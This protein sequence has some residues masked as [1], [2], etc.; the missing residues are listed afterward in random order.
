M[1]V[2]RYPFTVRPW[3]GAAI[4]ALAC[5]MQLAACG[6]SDDDSP[7]ASESPQ[8][9][10]VQGPTLK[11]SLS[12]IQLTTALKNGGANGRGL[13]A[14]ASGDAS[15]NATLACGV[16]THYYQYSTVDARGAP[17]TASGAIMLPD[18]PTGQCGGA[19]PMV[20]WAHGTNFYRQYNLA[21][22]LNASNPAASEGLVAASIYAS[23]GFIVVAPN[24]VG[25]DV[26]AASAHPYLNRIQQGQ[27]MVHAV[28]AA[29]LA[30]KAPPTPLVVSDSGKLFVSGYSQ[31]G[32]VAIAAQEAMERAGIKVTATAAGSAPYAI[33]TQV[34]YVYMGQPGYYGAMT[35]EL[36]FQGY[37]AA[38]GNIYSTPAEMLT[39]G[40]LVP[41]P[42]A[43]N[44]EG[45]Q[46]IVQPTTPMFSAAAPS[47]ADI[48]GAISVTVPNDRLSALLATTVPTGYVSNSPFAQAVSQVAWSQVFDP[49][50]NL[51]S[52][53]AAVSATSFGV[54]GAH[55]VR[56]SYRAAYLA[57]AYSNPDGFFLTG[58]AGLP[59]GTARNGLRIALARND[60]RGYVPTAPTLLC[61]TS[62]DAVVYFPLNT[63]AMQASW[64]AP[65]ATR[66]TFD[67]ASAPVPSGD[68]SH[69]FNALRSA[70][71]ASQGA[72]A[73][74]AGGGT[75]GAVA[76]RAQSH[77]TGS[78]FCNVAARA[79]FAN[80]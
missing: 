2:A 60:L 22:F 35:G 32:Y 43:S 6:G 61:G 23:Q 20:A 24:Y 75:R 19:R 14:L 31:G 5:C 28:R 8:G 71:A 80:F 76:A 10:L 3:I 38:Y 50:A 74:A 53:N 15:G 49:T 56:Q 48:P 58:G 70:Y 37:Q 18:G 47:L 17:V 4:S 66:F 59:S 57:D 29:R 51:A 33:A 21:D 9:T 16:Q 27:E 12:A 65:T 30:L 72:F 46:S 64:G 55:V 25:Y 44:Q 62:E 13:L 45:A 11:S 68:P 41:M 54:P 73:A 36:L 52:A 69:G 34:D 1:F 79:F 63:M 40:Y 7:T 26:S 67:L 42:F 77:I 78:A 39:D